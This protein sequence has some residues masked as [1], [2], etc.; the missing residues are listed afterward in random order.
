MDT[1][2]NLSTEKS[3]NI[4]LCVSFLCNASIRKVAFHKA[5]SWPVQGPIEAERAT[6]PLA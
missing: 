4:M 3:H 1:N 5:N 6:Q 2:A